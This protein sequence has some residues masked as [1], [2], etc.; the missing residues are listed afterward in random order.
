MEKLRF[1]QGT[2]AR[3]A[4]FALGLAVV[5]AG[6]FLL[7]SAFEPVETDAGEAHG[8]AAHGRHDEPEAA[9]TAA[10]GLAVSEGGYTLRLA[11]TFAAAG[12]E[13]RLRFRIEGPD[14]AAV[15][16]F[17]RLHEREMHLIVVRRDGAHFQHLH[18]EL[19]AT[20][21]WTAAATLPAAGAYR[22]FADFSVGGHDHTLAG[23]LFV[24]GSFAARPFP[25]PAALARTAGYEVRLDAASPRA[26]RP[27]ELRFLVTRDGR[28]VTDL[29]GY[30]GAKGH[31]V[32]L[33][34]GDLAFLH[35][36]PEEAAAPNEIPF[37]AHFPTPGRYRLY[38]QF[39]RAG[40]VRT[41]EFTVV[42]RR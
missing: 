13:R 33:R 11:P 37:A 7:G 26:G 8:D 6:S 28:E 4:L 25:G 41:A 12:E 3:I 39:K 16:D 31:L 17:D 32:A 20:G 1:P 42:V 29:Q 21:T 19:D 10:S 27:S 2:Q 30:L 5:F 23:D 40:A 14:G 9:A 15:R 24:S 36:H 34:E 35:V 22:A 38:L 18:P